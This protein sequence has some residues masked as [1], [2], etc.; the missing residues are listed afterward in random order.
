MVLVGEQRVKEEM[1]NA[2]TKCVMDHSTIFIM[3]YLTAFE[4]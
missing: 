4:E 2:H 1:A 3:K